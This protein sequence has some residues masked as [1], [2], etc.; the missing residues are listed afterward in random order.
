MIVIEELIKQTNIAEIAWFTSER[1]IDQIMLP[2]LETCHQKLYRNTEHWR[3]S[4]VFRYKMALLLHSFIFKLLKCIVR[5]QYLTLQSP[6]DDN[7]NKSDV[8]TL[9]IVNVTSIFH[10][11]IIISV[12]LAAKWLR[13]S[14][15]SL[16]MS[17]CTPVQ[18]TEWWSRNSWLIVL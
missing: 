3:Q 1:E 16:A 2:E 8:W 12:D 14:M 6:G 10:P 18:E 5:L 7:D 17:L 15:M 9:W 13:V 11:Q 4:L